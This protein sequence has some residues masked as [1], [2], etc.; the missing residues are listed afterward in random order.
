MKV[1]K[2]KPR[3]PI[4]I[5]VAKREIKLVTKVQDGKNKYSRKQK[6]KQGD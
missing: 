4:F 3:N 5:A 6:H 1:R 2:M